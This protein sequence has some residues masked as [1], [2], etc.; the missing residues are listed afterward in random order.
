MPTT[1]AMVLGFYQMKNYQDNKIMIDFEDY[2]FSDSTIISV[3]L[4]NN[5]ASVLFKNWREETCILEFPDHIGIEAFSPEGA[6]VSHGTIEREN[7]LKSKSCSYSE[8][9]PEEVNC[10]VL[11][12]AWN[13]DPILR[14]VSKNF[15]VRRA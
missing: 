3:C 12:S 1:Q 9:P 13:D 11:W 6:E 15:Q 10:Y 14:V 7:S 2:E 8:T 5:S 4:V